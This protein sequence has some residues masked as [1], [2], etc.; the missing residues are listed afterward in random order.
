MTLLTKPKKTLQQL[1]EEQGVSITTVWR[2]TPKGLAY[3]RSPKLKVYN[4]AYQRAYQKTPKRRAYVRAYQET[5]KYKVYRKVYEKTDKFKAIHK[6]SSRNY[7]K[8]EPHK[9]KVRDLAKKQIVKLSVCK[10][11]GATENLHRHHPDYSKPLNVIT[12]CPSCHG[13]EHRKINDRIFAYG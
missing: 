8:S 6:V 13:K 11:C 2:K 5:P 10:F 3:M 7:I 4:T 9:Q 1:A 12:L